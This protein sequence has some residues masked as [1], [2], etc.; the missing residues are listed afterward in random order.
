[1]KFWVYPLAPVQFMRI[2]M[3]TLKDISRESLSCTRKR[4]HD[5]W[6]AKVDLIDDEHAESYEANNQGRQDAG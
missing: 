6:L 1:M 5:W 3:G 4:A 2:T